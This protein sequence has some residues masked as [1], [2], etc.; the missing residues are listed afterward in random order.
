VARPGPKQVAPVASSANVSTADARTPG[1]GDDT[2]SLG[3]ASDVYADRLDTL[4]GQVRD[5]KDRIFRSKARL[6]LLKETVL[7]GVMAGSRVIVAHRN[8]MGSQF[9]LVS[10]A[11][12]LDGAQIFARQDETTG[13]LDELDELVVFDGNLVPGPHTVTVELEYRGRGFGSF[14]YLNN[15]TFESRSSHTFTAPENSAVRL[16]GI[17]FERGNMT[18][19]MRDRPAVDW[20]TTALDDSG[21]PKKKAKKDASDKAGS[22][23]SGGEKPAKDK[24]AKD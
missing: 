7:Q 23:K 17:G 18:T 4:D 14:S 12:S 6:Q 11:Y 5:L 1:V 15:Y 20:Q 8:V 21:K 10:V 9:R 22:A 13:S 16:T 24:A 19:E 2:V 3:R